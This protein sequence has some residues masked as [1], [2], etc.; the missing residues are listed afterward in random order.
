[1]GKKRLQQKARKAAP[2]AP[3]SSISKPTSNTGL[4]SGRRG[5]KK[6]RLDKRRDFIATEL[7]RLEDLQNSK[8]A[9][10]IQKRA[11]KQVGQALSLLHG[12]KDSLPSA[13]GDGNSAEQQQKNKN[14]SWSQLVQ[15]EKN[16]MDKVRNHEAFVNMGLDALTVHLS[17]TVSQAVASATGNTRGTQ[18]PKVGGKANKKGKSNT[19]MTKQQNRNEQGKQTGGSIERNAAER[20]EHK[21]KMAEQAVRMASK[22]RAQSKPQTLSSL[23]GGKHASSRGRIGEKR[24]KQL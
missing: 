11:Q 19:Y 4:L 15:Q 3:S 9:N 7:A 6:K 12:L 21:K 2:S 24:P 18:G 1:M 13:E 16:Q 10:L 8:L 5:Q 14:Q 20:R 23:L 17:N 22:Q